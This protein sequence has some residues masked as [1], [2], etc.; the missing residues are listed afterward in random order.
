MTRLLQSPPMTRARWLVPAATNCAA[1]IRAKMNPAQAAWMSNAGQLSL[2][3]SWTR[4]AGRG[5][6]HVG[7]ERADDQQ[8]DVAGVAVG[9][10]QAA[11]RR[12]GAEVARR[13]VG[14]REPALVDPRPVDDPLGVE[15]VRFLQVEV[16]D[17]VVG[18]VAARPQDLDPGQ[19]AGPRLDVELAVAAHKQTATVIDRGP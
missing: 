7:R 12:L 4:L 10:L 14:Q 8:V 18:D 15:P 9:R 16:A 19:R 6:A 1:V 2:S 13:L 17:H 11:D 5:K 3:R